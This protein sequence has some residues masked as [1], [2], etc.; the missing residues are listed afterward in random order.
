VCGRTLR[1]EEQEKGRCEYCRDELVA[2]QDVVGKDAEEFCRRLRD[3][4]R[5]IGLD[6][7]K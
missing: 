4:C 7:G 3:G 6:E 5:T 1:I 2:A